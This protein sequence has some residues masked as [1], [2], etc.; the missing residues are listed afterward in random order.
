MWL[1]LSAMDLFKKIGTFVFDGDESNFPVWYRQIQSRLALEGIADGIV[2]EGEGAVDADINQKAYHFLSCSLSGDVLVQF[3]DVNF[4]DGRALF[5]ALKQRFAP[6][7]AHHLQSLHKRLLETDYSAFSSVDE[8][9]TAIG[10]IRDLLVATGSQDRLSD[11]HIIA[12]V[13]RVVPHTMHPI[14]APFMELGV[15]NG[16][17]WSH[18]CARLRSFEKASGLCDPKPR[19]MMAAP[20]STSDERGSYAYR[21]K[22]VRPRGPRSSR[23]PPITCW[24]CG[25]EGHVE[26]RCLKKKKLID[27]H[28]VGPP[29]RGQGA[30]GDVGNA[31]FSF[32][33][34]LQHSATLP[35]SPN[36][37]CVDTGASQHV[38]HDRSLFVGDIHSTD[39]VIL[40][41]DGT[42]S[43]ASGVGTVKFRVKDTLGKDVDISL[44]N[45]LYVPSAKVNLLSVTKLVKVG[46]RMSA[47]RRPLLQARSR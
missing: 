46:G 13:C 35:V 14:T 7:D 16:G 31:H 25:E 17:T 34:I 20:H 6:A 10:K 36:L 26:R 44:M 41:A 12:H 30:S 40:V 42:R 47:W 28:R 22:A 23:K 5:R 32:P 27:E 21:P 24:F 45:T 37:F 43:T 18:L 19:A 2:N 15:E 29:A 38:C 11:K 39:A 3:S 4:G 33:A 8:F 1:C 9:L